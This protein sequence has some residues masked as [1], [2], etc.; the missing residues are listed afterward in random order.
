MVNCKSTKPLKKI[1]YKKKK[2]QPAK[3]THLPGA[4]PWVGVQL[5]SLTPPGESLSPW[6]QPPPLLGLPPRVQVSIRLLLLPA[7]LQ[8]CFLYRLGC[9]RAY[10]PWVAPQGVVFLTCSWRGVGAGKLS[11]LLLC[12]L[13]LPQRRKFLFQ[14]RAGVPEFGLLIYVGAARI[15]A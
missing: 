14:M 9:R 10:L 4:R 3:G 1:K 13:D 8:N 11:T 2:K 6:H 15:L 7:R 5:K 12:H